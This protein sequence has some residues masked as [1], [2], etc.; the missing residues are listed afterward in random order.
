MNGE[1]VTTFPYFEFEGSTIELQVQKHKKGGSKKQKCEKQIVK[2]LLN[3]VR[4]SNQTKGKEKKTGYFFFSFSI[5]VVKFVFR[6]IN[7]EGGKQGT[8]K[9][10][11]GKKFKRKKKNTRKAMEKS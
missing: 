6:K 10:G 5:L 9:K 4:S 8:P 3:D 7:I 11:V 1:F 2:G